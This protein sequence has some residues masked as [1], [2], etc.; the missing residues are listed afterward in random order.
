MNDFKDNIFNIVNRQFE[1]CAGR[2]IQPNLNLFSN[3]AGFIP[4]TILYVI[5]SIENELGYA[6]TDIF[7]GATSSMM[8]IENI[9]EKI[10]T[11]SLQ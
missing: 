11:I 1:N 6:I 4:R 9:A 7:K 8:T 3:E 10:S 2:K 5:T